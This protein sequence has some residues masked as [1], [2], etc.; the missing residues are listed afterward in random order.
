[1]LLLGLLSCAE[2]S[3]AY[4][5]H[6]VLPGFGYQMGDL[7]MQQVTISAD[8]DAEID[9]LVM[10]SLPLPGSV[11]PWLDLR[12]SQFRKT[13]RKLHLTLTW[14]LFATVDQVQT[15]PIPPHTI[16]VRGQPKLKLVIP[17]AYV[18]VSPIFEKPMAMHSRYANIPAPAFDIAGP[19]VFLATGLGLLA[20]SGLAW[21]WLLGR[22]PDWM[23]PQSPLGKVYGQIRVLP[24]G[25]ALSPDQLR[26][27]HAALN[28]IAQTT[29]YPD[30]L[31]PL[32][33]R[34]AYLQPMRADISRFFQM[35]WQI[36]FA[37]AQAEITREQVLDWLR[38]AVLAER[39]A[40]RRSARRATP[41]TKRH[42]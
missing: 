37:G 29:L 1:M 17:T 7:V 26:A 12:D 18:Q 23:L 28:A 38:I 8:S 21:L 32:F 27:M 5:V 41:P 10:E 4:Q 14:Q 42:S 20:C 34:A 36:F 30:R 13:D 9:A 19:A 39:L 2:A 31:Q 33:E 11:K 3:A 15:L 24:S 22:L 16:R 25:Q 6:S 40:L 35:S